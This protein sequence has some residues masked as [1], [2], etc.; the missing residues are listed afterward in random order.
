[1]DIIVPTTITD[2]ILLSSNV[3]ETEYAEWNPGSTYTANAMVQVTTGEHNIYQALTN[4]APNLNKSPAD[5]PTFWVLISATNRYKM[6]DKYVS[7]PT[8]VTGNIDV[9]LQPGVITSLSML[10]IQG[11]RV[12]V[13]MTSG[14]GELVYNKTIDLLRPS[15]KTYFG[16]FN[17]RRKYRKTIFLDDLPNFYEATTRVIIEPDPTGISMCGMLVVG[18]STFV[19][20]LRLDS[21]GEGKDYS[22]VVT[23][24]WGES[25]IKIGSSARDLNGTL[26]VDELDSD[27][28][29]EFMD[30]IVGVP[31]FINGADK[32]SLRIFGIRKSF[33]FA[34]PENGYALYNFKFDGFI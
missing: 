4:A 6:F 8:K 32:D 19:G 29:T 16:Y 18:Y 23:D 22:R 26:W 11:A 21:G 13:L 25:T 9:L 27:E 28:V 15:T 14:A 33:S 31:V 5:N 1:M 10:G 34:Y 3:P 2:S 20:H 7:T 24:Q 12:T 30:S 17:E